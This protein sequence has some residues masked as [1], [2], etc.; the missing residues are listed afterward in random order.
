MKVNEANEN[1]VSYCDTHF[2]NDSVTV[3]INCLL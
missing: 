1:K 2:V 3:H